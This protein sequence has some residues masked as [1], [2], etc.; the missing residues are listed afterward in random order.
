MSGCGE[1][2][3]H[4]SGRRTCVNSTHLAAHK[5]PS[6]FTGQPWRQRTVMTPDAAQR[7]NHNWPLWRCKTIQTLPT[8]S[9]LT[10]TQGLTSP[11]YTASLV[12]PVTTVLD[13]RPG[14]TH[15]AL[16]VVTEL[17]HPAPGLWNLGGLL[18][19]HTPLVR[20]WRTESRI[21]SVC[22]KWSHQGVS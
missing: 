15:G 3:V 1:S 18:G 11:W 14:W 5:E 13:R 4:P 10:T 20:V 16:L 17:E 22:S 6:S 19:H 8:V 21:V 2:Q 7:Q 12:L 9:N